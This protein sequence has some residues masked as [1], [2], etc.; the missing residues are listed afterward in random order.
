MASEHQDKGEHKELQIE[1]QMSMS[2]QEYEKLNSDLQNFV[3]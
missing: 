1:P 3:S 2:Y